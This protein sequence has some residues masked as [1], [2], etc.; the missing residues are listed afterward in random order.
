MKKQTSPYYSL[1]NIE[2]LLNVKREYLRKIANTAGAYYDPFDMQ[3]IKSDGKIKWRHIDNP[4]K[5][6]KE[7]QRKILKKILLKNLLQLP[8][9]MIGG[10]AGKSIKDNALPHT[11]QEMVVTIDIKD[12]FPNTTDKMI[13]NVWANTVDCGRQSSLFTKLTTF[14]TILPQGAPTSSALCNLS[15]LP[16]FNEIK[17]YADANNIAFTLYVDDITIS[18]KVINVLPAIGTIIKKIQKY[19]FGVRR[20]KIAIMPANVPQKTT[21]LNTNEKV[22]IAQRKIE[23]V[24]NKIL[25]IAKR[26]NGITTREFNSINGD[27]LFIHGITKEKAEKLREFA[28]LL[29]PKTLMEGEGEEEKKP[30]TTKCRHHKRNK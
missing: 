3:Q 6:L 1:E 28:D 7:I 14:R 17:V 4:Q 11:K 10:V 9:G 2:R 8:D 18:G 25:L 5:P 13:F 24:R 21:G 26:I 29:L 23:G 19:G 22:N 20:E 16:L 27:I 30:I 15:L 12:C